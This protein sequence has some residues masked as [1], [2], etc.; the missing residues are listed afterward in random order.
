MIFN[1]NDIEFEYYKI[2]WSDS[3]RYLNNK[4]C[5]KK[6]FHKIFDK[7]NQPPDKKNNFWEVY[8]T[9]ERVSNLL[10][11]LAKHPYLPLKIKANF[12]SFLEDSGKWIL[13]NLEYYGQNQTNNHFL[14]NG[15]A[16]LMIGSVINDDNL[17][18]QGFMILDIFYLKFVTNLI[19]KRRFNKLSVDYIHLDVVVYFLLKIKFLNLNMEN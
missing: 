15:R 17:I 16:L 13:S 4:K 8:S 7:I 5:A 18:N 2:R 12:V 3:I 1:P 19:Y 9:C 14:N 10:I 6:Y 11:F